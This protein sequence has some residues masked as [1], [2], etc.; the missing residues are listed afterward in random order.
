MGKTGTRAGRGLKRKQL[1]VKSRRGSE[2]NPTE[3]A[4]PTVEAGGGGATAARGVATGGV[5]VVTEGALVPMAAEGGAT[6]AARAETGAG[7]AA[8]GGA[9]D[10]VAVEATHGAALTAVDTGGAA[11]AGTG[12]IPADDKQTQ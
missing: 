1:T 6:A 8:E 2:T 4:A 12:V 5:T 11:A 9:T 7:A 3:A 10:A